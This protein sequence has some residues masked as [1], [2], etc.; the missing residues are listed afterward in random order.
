MQFLFYELCG[1]RHVNS[2]SEK[3]MI[4]VQVMSLS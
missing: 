1:Y 4:Q 3:L 2:L